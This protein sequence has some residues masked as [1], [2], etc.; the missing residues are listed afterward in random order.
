VAIDRRV[1]EANAPSAREEIQTG[2]KNLDS[3]RGGASRQDQ[4][5]VC[6]LRLS[7]SVYN[8]TNE[9][10]AVTTASSAAHSNHVS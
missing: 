5:C 9:P 4:E 2:K 6:G 1:E 8:Q 7:V 3:I 10:S